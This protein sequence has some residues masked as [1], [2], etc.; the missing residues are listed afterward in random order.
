M[1]IENILFPKEPIEQADQEKD[2]GRVSCVDDVKAMPAPYLQAEQK[3][4]KQGDA[5][6]GQIGQILIAYVWKSIAVDRDP[7]DACGGLAIG[8][9]ALR[10]DDADLAAVFVQGKGFRPDPSIR[11]GGDIFDEHEYFTG[12]C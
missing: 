4:H 6:L 2:I 11:G 8:F 1:L 10:A 3:G 9:L 5:I 7:V 12:F